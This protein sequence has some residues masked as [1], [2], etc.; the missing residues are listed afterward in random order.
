MG[1]GRSLSKLLTA[2]FSIKLKTQFFR[3]EKKRNVI[4]SMLRSKRRSQSSWLEKTPAFPTGKY[5]AWSFTSIGYLMCFL[6]HLFSFHFIFHF[7]FTASPPRC[8]FQ[9]TVLHAPID[10]L[11]CF[12]WEPYIP[13]DDKCSPLQF[14]L[15]KYPDGCHNSS[16]YFQYLAILSHFIYHQNSFESQL[17]QRMEK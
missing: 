16:L 2:W 1:W 5:K 8:S 17:L 4:F 6:A 10:K 9:W 13:W 11:K 7:L 3:S 12:C 15:L 14:M